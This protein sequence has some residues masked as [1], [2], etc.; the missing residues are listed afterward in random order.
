L[1]WLAFQD[2]PFPL[3]S[4]TR[5][6]FENKLKNKQMKYALVTG[7]SSGIGYAIVKKLLEN[8]FFVWGSVRN[9]SDADKLEVDF[10]TNFEALVFDV[11]DAKAVEKAVEIVQKRTGDSGLNILV[12]NAGIALTGPMQLI[13]NTDL[14]YQF[15]VNVF[16]VM[17]VTRAFLP[18]LGADLK[19]LRADKGTIVN[20]SSISALITTPFVGAYCS[21]KAALDVLMDALRRELS[22]FGIHKVVS[23]QPGPVKTPIWEK[24]RQKM[25]Y[26]EGSDYEIYLKNSEKTIRQSEK[27][28]IEVE[29]VADLVWAIYENPRPKTRYVIA[30]NGFLIKM[31][32]RLPHRWLDNI[33][34]KQVA[35]MK[36]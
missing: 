31:V 17:N 5:Q 22:I 4:L 20:I 2:K 15:D 34:T 7:A 3:L 30:K 12:N 35:D 18:L 28:A 23:I 32:S 29:K 8:G 6:I 9:T 16:G 26:Y 27:M 25:N 33:L 21:S 36:K 19:N 24:A 10:E 1:Q 14:K 11:I 13:S